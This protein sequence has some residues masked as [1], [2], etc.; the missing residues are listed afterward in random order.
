ML[1]IPHALTG[2]FI[3]S[4]LPYPVVYIPMAFGMHY[5]QDWTPHWDVGT[6]LSNGKRKKSTAILLEF[7]DLG[8]AVGLIYWFFKSA[9]ADNQMHIW[10]GALSG[11][12][13]DLIEA[14]RNFLG[15]EPEFLKPLNKIHGGFH[16]S[17]PKI[18]F[19]LIPQLIVILAI[20]L[21]R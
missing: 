14:P 1:S 6:G 17:T 8:I 19:G 18:I 20:W 3:A 5:L 13:P 21:L 7:V 10:L 11:I 9:P 15:W 12:T 4:K 2:A 16:N